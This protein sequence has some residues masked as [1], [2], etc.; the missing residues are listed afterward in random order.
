MKLDL[1]TL[2]KMRNVLGSV[3]LLAT[4]V[5]MRWYGQQNLETW[6]AAL[7]L[8]A[9]GVG[10]RTWAS[11][12]CTYGLKR[13]K[14]TGLATTGPYTVSRNPLYI[15]TILVLLGGTVASGV[16]WLV[17]V[18]LV[19]SVLAYT[20][21]IMREERRLRDR[22]GEAYVEFC[23]ATPRWLPTPFGRGDTGKVMAIL[24]RQSGALLLLLPFLLG[25]FDWFGLW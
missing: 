16:L 6:G 12:H 4:L 7:V 22:Y 11:C 13:F 5:C 17:P 3:P 9:A 25:E 18:T 8:G 19:W 23:A 21:V 20:G 2:F 10:L 24:L 14:K 15:G 1:E